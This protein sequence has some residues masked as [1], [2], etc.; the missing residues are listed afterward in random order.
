MPSATA[1]NIKSSRTR[2]SPS[3]RVHLSKRL[4]IRCSPLQSLIL[5][6]VFRQLAAKAVYSVVSLLRCSRLSACCADQIRPTVL[7]GEPLTPLSLLPQ[8]RSSTDRAACP[9]SPASLK[10]PFGLVKSQDSFCAIA[11]PIGSQGECRSCHVAACTPRFST[12]RGTSCRGV[13][14]WRDDVIG[15]ILPAAV[16]VEDTPGAGLD[17]FLFAGR[18]A[19]RGR[20]GEPPSVVLNPPRLGATGVWGPHP[21]GHANRG[22]G[23]RRDDVARRS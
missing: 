21:A 10:V 5:A 1:A 14:M 23:A 22:G 9:H 11:Q 6:S 7:H 12:R 19:P 20:G 2:A 16:F 15:E 8:Q 3:D 13:H 18:G 4:P 17:C